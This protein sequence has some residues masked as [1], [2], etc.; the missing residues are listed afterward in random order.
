MVS[1]RQGASTQQQEASK[2]EERAQRILDAAATLILRWGYNKTTIDDI[3][4]QA[5]VAKGTIYLHWKTREDLFLALIRREKI[6]LA[7]DLKRRIAEDPEGGTLRGIF[8][9]SALAVMQR[10][11]MKAILL[12]DM[13]VLGKLSQGELSNAAHLE[14]LEGFKT[15]LEVLRELG[16]V[17][18][19][20]SLQA[21]A[22]MISA[23][24]SGFLLVIPF[25]PDEFILPDEEIADL[26]AE[27]IHRT[28]EPGHVLSS[29]V[30]QAASNSSI[31]Y[32]DHYIVSQKEQFQ[33][34]V[35]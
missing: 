18:T 25:M 29:D 20:L 15:Y 33:Q 27:T 32:M 14:R 2:R 10:P 16:V 22:Y 28:L 6:E 5:G 31:Q 19:D 30:L 11:L 7:E 21:Q 13:E 8:K 35:S 34:D 12:R 1:Q 23:I 4:R 3:S 17:R 26:M 9:H 24:M